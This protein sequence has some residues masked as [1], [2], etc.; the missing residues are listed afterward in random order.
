MPWPPGWATSLKSL[1]KAGTHTRHPETPAKATSCRLLL[2]TWEQ[3]S[4]R[5]PTRLEPM[6][7]AGGH[8]PGAPQMLVPVLPS[9]LPCRLRTT[10]PPSPSQ[11]GATPDQAQEHT[12]TEGRPEANNCI[13]MSAGAL[14]RPRGGQ[15]RSAAEEGWHQPPIPT[16]P[17]GQ[18]MPLGRAQ[19]QH[20]PA[21]SNKVGFVPSHSFQL[22]LRPLVA[23]SSMG[24]G[25]WTGRGGRAQLGPSWAEGPSGRAGFQGRAREDG[26]VWGRG[27]AQRALVGL[28][29][30]LPG[31]EGSPR[32]HKLGCQAW[33]GSSN[34]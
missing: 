16:P 32:I 15:Q 19:S 23:S 6:G 3:V 1:L 20:H 33:V 10:H 27:S 26:L 31:D 8:R 9:Q 2:Q 24:P 22:I 28:G 17:P 4:P 11:V 13:S 29:R 30:G 12:S 14:S 7:W 18:Y 25:H 34:A 5:W 21:G